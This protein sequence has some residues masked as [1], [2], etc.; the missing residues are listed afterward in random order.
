MRFLFFL[1]NKIKAM[2]SLPFL[3]DVAD[4]SELVK[5]VLLT[6]SLKPQKVSFYTLY[7]SSPYTLHRIH[8]HISTHFSFHAQNT[9]AHT[10]TH[11]R[12]HTL[13][14]YSIP[15]A[16]AGPLKKKKQIE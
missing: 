16:D 10:R 6:V 3:R 5:Q 7:T 9:H 11:T 12:K 14:E 1:F 2:K 13:V 8:T 15:F 4:C